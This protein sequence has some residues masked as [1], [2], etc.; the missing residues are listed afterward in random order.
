MA[1]I[2][3]ASSVP[4]E[5]PVS[6]PS[7]DSSFSNVE[8]VE[9]IRS[10]RLRTLWKATLLSI[11]FMAWII[12]LLTG[13]SETT[14]LDLV[15]PV[16]FIG[17]ASALTNML[18]N[19][20]YY[21]TAI[22]TY[23]LGVIITIAVMTGMA[24]D[25]GRDFIP[26]LGVL[27]IFVVGM[28]M[29]VMN[30][31]ILLGISYVAMIG[32]P[33]LINGEMSVDRSEMFALMLMG[34]A[35]LLVAQVSGE[36]YGI[37]EWALDSYRKER[38][39]ATQLHESRLE[40]E[41][42]LLKQKNLTA[43]LQE[44]NEAL[45]DARR[46]AEM[47]K[48]FRGVFLANMSHELRTPLNAIIG[49]SDT[50]LNFPVMYGGAELPGEYRADLEQI[51]TSGNH[52]LNIINDI[53]DLSKID[54]GRLEIEYEKVELEPLFKGVLAQAVG[55]IGGKPIELQRDMPDVLPDVWGDPLRI[56]QVIINLYSNAAKFTQEGSI[57]L[58]V[59]THRDK[60]IISV[61]DTGPGIAT[62]NLETIFEAFRQGS[63]GKKQ[64][65]QGAGLG[66]AISRE[67]LGLMEGEI[68]AESEI[69]QGAT[70][71]ISLPRYKGEFEKTPESAAEA[72]WET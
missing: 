20:E 44:V 56:R 23:A 61:T 59:D 50:M 66:L 38:S 63:S 48:H 51:N 4:L 60:V 5:G 10:N 43:Q 47:A 21:N 26:F 37:A 64:K 52:L 35:A 24:G 55:L 53:L 16:L 42:S 36:L 71:Y 69:D 2:V 39:T 18:L 70:F 11:I 29:S 41:K 65:R 6:Q 31:F 27:V 32:I 22:W 7:T 15:I 62:D 8:F 25:T 49:F 57:T 46:S 72:S 30:T 33:M 40:I 14:V 19:R 1:D 34:L 3:N 28:L 13:T 67:L 17:G 45:D 58:G 12:L 54:A 9:E 68:W